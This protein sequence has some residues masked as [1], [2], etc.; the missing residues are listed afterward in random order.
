MINGNKGGNP[1]HDENGRFTS[2]ENASGS[3]TNEKVM[4]Q[5]GLSNNDLSDVDIIENSLNNLIEYAKKSGIKNPVPNKEWD[6]DLA[7]QL[8]ND[9]VPEDR[10]PSLLKKFESLVPNRG[11]EKFAP[12]DYS[13]EFTQKEIDDILK[14][15][16]SRTDSFPG[17]NPHRKKKVFVN[18]E[19][20]DN[21]VK[22]LPE[23]ADAR[24]DI[25]DHTF[26]NEDGEPDRWLTYWEVYY[27]E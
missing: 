1:N 14:S 11:E 10:I 2:K 13:T 27:D 8:K 26:T 12:N 17:Q 3:K 7:Y 16:D 18:K 24:M 20:R 15:I 23:N 19:E 21:F 4:K 9:G 5:M 25:F 22:S 6:D